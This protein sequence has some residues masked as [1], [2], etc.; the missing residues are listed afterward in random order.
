MGRQ[1]AK[2]SGLGNSVLRCIERLCAQN[3]M[4]RCQ[5]QRALK[6]AE[7]TV[8]QETA[9]DVRLPERVPTKEAE[10]NLLPEQII[11][12]LDVLNQKLAAANRELRRYETRVFACE[13]TIYAL[14]Q[15][16]AELTAL[17]RQA[18]RGETLPPEPP[19]QESVLDKP[20]LLIVRFTP[21]G[22]EQSEQLNVEAIPFFDESRPP[23]PKPFQEPKTPLEHLTIQLLT[24]FDRMM[25]QGT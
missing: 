1:D 23:C 2:D 6:G 11:A 10:T 4:E 19:P 20:G 13:R 16:N 8:K 25:S 14:R 18:R 22:G 15:E 12:Q 24:Q 7:K 17:C 21:D 5:A 9:A 3:A